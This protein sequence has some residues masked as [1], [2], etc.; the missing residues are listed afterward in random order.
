VISARRAWA[1]VAL[2]WLT[3]AINYVDRQ[4]VFSIYPVLRREIGFSDA[5]LGLIGSTFLWIYSFAILAGG[6]VADMLPRARVVVVS[7]VLWSLATLGTGLSHSVASFLAWRALVGVTEA[8]YVPAALALIATLHPGPTRS[9]AL[10]FHATAQFAGIIGGGWFGGWMADSGTW[11]GGLAGLSAFGLVYG[12]VLVWQFRPLGGRAA[13]TGHEHASPLAVFGSRCYVSLACVFFFYCAMLWMLYAWLPN[14]VYEHFGL[15]MASAGFVSTF[16]LQTSTMIGVLT[17]GVL[18]DRFVGRVPA[19][20]FYLAG[21]GLLACSPMA[22]IG[23]TSTSLGVLKLGC[24]AFGFSAGIFVANIFAGSYDVTAERNY[25]FATGLLNCI[26]GIA[27]GA[28]MFL[29]G[30]WKQTVGMAALMGWAGLATAVGAV[31]LL[32]TTRFQFARDRARVL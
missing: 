17:G 4:V 22:W 15:S 8:L 29:A 14:W 13:R 27:G 11:R 24:A 6:R 19:I 32:A 25:G 21:L 7:L 23:L 30:Y 3:Y 10:A 18:A 20:R 1:V 26:G 28:A 31:V 5:Q 2:L 9:K 12:A 16:Y